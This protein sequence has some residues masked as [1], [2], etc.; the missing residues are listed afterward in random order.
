MAPQILTDRCRRPD[1]TGSETRMTPPRHNSQQ[2]PLLRSLAIVLLVAGTAVPVWARASSDPET[3]PR[4]AM[5]GQP[6]GSLAAKTTG[7]SSLRAALDD[8]VRPTLEDL[9]QLVSAIVDLK[10]EVLLVFDHEGE[11]LFYTEGKDHRVDI[12]RRQVAQLRGGTLLHNHPGGT[13][14]SG[15]D[16]A[17]LCRYGVRESIVAARDEGVIMQARIGLRGAGL[18][19]A[20][21]GC[22]A[23]RQP[24]TT[25]PWS[26]IAFEPK[27]SWTAEPRNRLA[28]AAYSLLG[29]WL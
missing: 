18:Q 24:S 1:E 22:Q 5:S 6:A 19:A 25:A 23:G 3:V 27:P 28:L 14:P 29:G 4:L 10:Y 20:L 7:W 21:Q 15:I 2:T 9:P 16:Y 12:P 8:G 13:P 11:F 17:A 26:P